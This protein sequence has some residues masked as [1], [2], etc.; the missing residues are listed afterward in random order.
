MVRLQVMKAEN[1]GEGTMFVTQPPI[2]D[3]HL[4]LGPEE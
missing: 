4:C 3:N 1:R 2:N